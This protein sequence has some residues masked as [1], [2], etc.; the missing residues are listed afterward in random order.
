MEFYICLFLIVVGMLIAFICVSI[1]VCLG[2]LDK[3]ELCDSNCCKSVCNDTL[4]S[5][6]STVGDNNRQVNSR[7]DLG[8]DKEKIARTL[9]ILRASASSRERV[10]IDYC[11]DK[12]C[13]EVEDY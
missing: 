6:N 4:S 9:Y 5:S 3:N 13:G 7:Q 1:G 2:R 12:L 11:I 8:L 10:V